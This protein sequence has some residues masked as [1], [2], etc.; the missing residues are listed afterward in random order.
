MHNVGLGS[1][2]G[3]MVGTI[4]GLIG[5]QLTLIEDECA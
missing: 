4:F 5:W 3:A 1:E 2:I